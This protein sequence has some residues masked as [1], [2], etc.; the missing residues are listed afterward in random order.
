VT[1]ATG[2]GARGYDV[3]DLAASAAVALIAD[4]TP[5]EAAALGA[6]DRLPGHT[7]ES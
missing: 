2:A 6:G 1:V 7:L 4:V 5:G 3:V